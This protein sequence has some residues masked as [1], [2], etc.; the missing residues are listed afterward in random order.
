MKLIYGAAWAVIIGFLAWSGNLLIEIQSLGR[1]SSGLHELTGSLEDLADTWQDLNRPGNNVLE[2][3]DVTAHRAALETYRENYR[4][5]FERVRASVRD[6]AVLAPMLDLLDGHQHTLAGLAETVLGLASEREW[7]RLN[8]ADQAVVSERETQAGAAMARMDQVFQAGLDLILHAG[9]VIVERE[10]VIEARQAGN[11]NRLY[12]MLLFALVASALSLELIRRIMRKREALRESAARIG[13]IVDNV[14]DGIVAIDERG[15]V[16]SANRPGERMFGY[17]PGELIGQPFETLLDEGCRE[18]YRQRRQRGSGFLASEECEELGLR[19]DRTRF[20]IELAVSEVNTEGRRLSIHIIRDVTYRRQADQKLRLAASVFEN[21]S[22]GI[23]VTDSEGTIQSVN[24]AYAAISRFPAEELVGQN[25]R[26]LKSGHHDE[27]FY[28][29][30]WAAISNNGCWKGEVWNRRANGEVFPQWLTISAI[31]DGRGRTTN[32]VGVAWDISELKASER[33]KEEFITTVSHELRTPLTSVLGS[34]SML[35]RDMTPDMPEHARRLVTLAHSNSRRL[36]RL[37]NDILDIEKM[38]TGRMTFEFEPLELDAI[39]AQ[40]VSDCRTLAEESGVE[41]R[42]DA[43]RPAHWVSGDADRLMQALT[44]LVANAIKFS[45]RGAFV[46][47]ATDEHDG[48][49]RVS[50]T[51]QGPGIPAEFHAEVFNRFAQLNDPKARAKGGT[52]LGLS[53][54]KLIVRQ[55]GGTIDFESAPGVRTTFFI[56]LPAMPVA[57]DSKVAGASGGGARSG[58]A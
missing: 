1:T 35:M 45:P 52:G 21:T 39:V 10:R 44:N 33:K 47:V 27:A 40:V 34:L 4:K 7:L 36:V 22:E 6:D 9:L 55:H 12:V 24:P 49:Y 43:L 8:Q 37:I 30:M 32:Y 56:D 14:V 54:A 18:T 57:A 42:V 50:I 58:S 16:E 26:L 20:P 48:M 25:P 5:R 38:K 3:Y 51:D 53:I 11:F 29:A 15:L 41:I 13:T 23:V 17:A 2:N 19:R 28:R 46:Q 31:K